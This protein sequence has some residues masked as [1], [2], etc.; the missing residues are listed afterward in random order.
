MTAYKTEKDAHDAYMDAVNVDLMSA[1]D[2]VKVAN[3]Y[4][5]MRYRALLDALEDALSKGQTIPRENAVA[6][7]GTR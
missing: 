5:N 7:Y 6:G 1:E 4:N 3:I 2:A